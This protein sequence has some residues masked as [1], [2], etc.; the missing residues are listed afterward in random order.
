MTESHDIRSLAIIPRTVAECV[1]LAERLATS[2][3]LPKALRNKVPD[4]LMTI[5]A[6]QE[7]G[8]APM[9]ALR[10]FHVIEGKPVMGAD[11]LVAVV[12]GSGKAVYFERIE[13]TDTS[14]TYETLRVGAKAPKRCTWT[15]AQAKAAALDKKDNWRLYP[16]PMLAARA[17][18]E[19]ARDV[20]PDVVAGC[21]I[22]DE[23]SDWTPPSRNDDAIDADIVGETK[24]SLEDRILA[25]ESIEALKALVPTINALKHGTAERNQAKAAYQSQHDR[26]IKASAQPVGVAG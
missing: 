7:M 12:L 15:M 3:L 23:T 22:D 8:L 5:M 18:A 11:G 16:R 10:S 20:Y 26:L 14:V 9:A 6:G 2:E 1:D 4:V 21:Y 25:T 19:L 24:S 13:E 17:K